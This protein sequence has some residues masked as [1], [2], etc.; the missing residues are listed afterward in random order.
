MVKLL[1]ALVIGAFAKALAP[2]EPPL[3]IDSSPAAPIVAL[4]VGN[5]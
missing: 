1:V 4:D 3:L 2:S 5:Q